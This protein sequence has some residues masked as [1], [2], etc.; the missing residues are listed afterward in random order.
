MN[1]KEYIRAKR[2]MIF[3]ECVSLSIICAFYIL[4]IYIIIVARG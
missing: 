4:I 1:R 2:K 3:E